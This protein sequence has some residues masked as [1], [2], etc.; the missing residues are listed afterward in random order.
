MIQ[1]LIG[2]VIS[3]AGL[4]LGKTIFNKL[5][6]NKETESKIMPATPT[7]IEKDDRYQK[8]LQQYIIEQE[9]REVELKQLIFSST[10]MKGEEIL[11]EEKWKELTYKQQQVLINN[12][13]EKDKRI[14]EL[15]EQELQQIQELEC[16]KLKLLEEWH[17][18][19]FA[20]HNKQIL[21][22]WDLSNWDSKLNRE[23]TEDLLQI[24]SFRNRLLVLVSRPKITGNPLFCDEI[25]HEQIKNAV[26]DLNE[27][28]PRSELEIYCDY[29]KNPIED[30]DIP[31]LKKILNSISTL[32]ISTHVI[33]NRIH[34]NCVFWN[35]GE[36]EIRIKTPSWDL[37]EIMK[38]SSSQDEAVLAVEEIIALVH[39]LL[40]I[41]AKDLY[42]LSL[43]FSYQPVLL[44]G[45]FQDIFQE[46]I[47]S[48]YDPLA[49]YI[50]E[51]KCGQQEQLKTSFLND[52]LLCS[53]KEI[54][55]VK[56]TYTEQGQSNLYEYW[57]CEDESDSGYKDYLSTY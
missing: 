38:S 39:K 29:F 13:A 37:S 47:S 19:K 2:A 36:E 17:Q 11:Q 54:S 40:I 14:L 18:E 5:S 53:S 44:S 41:Y 15:K 3:G 28:I 25:L 49:E 45:Y 52:N 48:L 4:A 26:F 27:Y 42:F 55:H 30:T 31:R 12:A 24:K 9:K 56:Q 7:V 33:R 50:E 34:I 57:D 21:Q 51:I 32:V 8:L 16:L 22:D 35:M 6:S 46:D 20:L 1:R 23:E 43:S 10:K